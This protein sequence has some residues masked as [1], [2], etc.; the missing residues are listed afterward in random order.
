MYVGAVREP[1]PVGQF[2][3]YVERLHQNENCG[4][5]EEYKVMVYDCQLSKF[6]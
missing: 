6:V 4:F 5:G 3:S 2:A 1:I